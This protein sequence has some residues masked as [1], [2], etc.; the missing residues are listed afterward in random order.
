MLH[1]ILIATRVDAASAACSIGM[2]QN[3]C[4]AR[5]L[6]ARPGSGGEFSRYPIK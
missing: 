5:R 2:W 4:E 1:E 6:A 3:F